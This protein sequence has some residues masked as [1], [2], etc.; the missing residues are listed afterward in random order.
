MKEVYLF[1][2]GD[3]LMVDIPGVDGK[4]CDWNTVEAVDGAFETLEHLSRTA[5]IYIA[6]AA[7]ES[8][9]MDIQKALDRVALSQF[10]SGY[11]C[12]ANLGFGK[13]DPEFLPAIIEK[14]DQPASYIT[15]VGDSLEKD[16]LPAVAAGIRSV[17]FSNASMD[18]APENIRVIGSLRE[19]C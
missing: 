16:V 7:A 11:F 12:K 3:T 13:G 1:D 2:W 19:L 15:M 18:D 8:S 5:T 9:E 14:L 4:M 6:S 17:W 10:I